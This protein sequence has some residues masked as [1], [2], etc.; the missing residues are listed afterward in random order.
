MLCKDFKYIT[1]DMLVIIT[2]KGGQLYSTIVVGLGEPTA[3]L[4]VSHSKTSKKQMNV[5]Y[6]LR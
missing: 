2:S 6:L 1:V 5:R 3:I 4:P